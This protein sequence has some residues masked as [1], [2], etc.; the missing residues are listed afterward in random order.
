MA[1]F[2][3]VV[4]N[5]LWSSSGNFG[6]EVEARWLCGIQLRVSRPPIRAEIGSGD[7]SLEQGDERSGGR[8]LGIGC[9]RPSPRLPG[10]GHRDHFRAKSESANRSD[11]GICKVEDLSIAG[12]SESRIYFRNRK[13]SHASRK[14]F[15][16]ARTDRF[17]VLGTGLIAWFL[18]S[19]QPRAHRVRCA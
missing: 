18:S 1:F 15:T 3:R 8:V 13:S 19:A 5:A 17:S 7:L 16:S 11:S 2:W 10:A 9:A 6:R 4:S 12:F 14:K